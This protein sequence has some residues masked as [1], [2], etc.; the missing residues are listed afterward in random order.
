MKVIYAKYRCSCG[1]EDTDKLFENER[2]ALVVNCFKCHAGVGV[3]HE[4]QLHQKKGMIL[5]S[6]K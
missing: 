4:E 2:P 1:A 5:V 3:P 6:A